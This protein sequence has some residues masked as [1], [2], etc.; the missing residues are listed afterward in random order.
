[1]KNKS[2]KRKKHRYHIHATVVGTKYVGYVEAYNKKEAEELAWN[3][4][5]C[6]SDVCYQCSGD[7][8]QDPEITK[9]FLD[10]TEV[11]V[12][13]QSKSMPT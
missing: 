7:Q 13:E 12:H 8:I 11:N 2:K 10:R 4:E 9:L 6:Y 5:N 1:M 3:H